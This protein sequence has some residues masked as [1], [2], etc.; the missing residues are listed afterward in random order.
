[1]N[2]AS[3]NTLSI[4]IMFCLGFALLRMPTEKVCMKLQD[5]K[6]CLRVLRNDIDR[7]RGF[8]LVEAIRPNEG[9]LYL[10]NDTEKPAF[11]MKDVLQQLD[12]IFIDNQGCVLELVQAK[13]HDTKV[14]I[15]P[16]NSMF[17]V[18]LAGGVAMQIKLI[19]GSKLSPDVLK[20]LQVVSR[21]H[22]K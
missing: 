17:A 2:I 18:E 7:K 9:L 22:A 10:L 20:K 16:D 21:G 5:Q 19:K 13:P 3:K 15:P 4:I 1:L 6:V 11:W 14:I 8:Q 12:L